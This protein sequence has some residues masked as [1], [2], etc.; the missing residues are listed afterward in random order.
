LKLIIG[1]LPYSGAWNGNLY[2]VTHDE[3]YDIINTLI[4]GAATNTVLYVDDAAISAPNFKSSITTNSPV[5]KY[6]INNTN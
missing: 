6:T 1:A 2:A 5:I 4:G 3:A